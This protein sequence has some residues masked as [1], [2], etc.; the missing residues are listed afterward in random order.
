MIDTTSHSLVWFRNDLRLHDNP[1]LDRALER[2]HPI[3]FLYI[4]ETEGTDTRALGGASQWWLH[5]SLQALSESLSWKGATLTLRTGSPSD[6]FRDIRAQHSI[7]HVYWNRRYA[8]DECEADARL[9]AEL[10]SDGI[11]VE[12]FSSHLLAEPW[13]VKTRTDGHF[14]VFSPFWRAVQKLYQP[15]PA[16]SLPNAFPSAKADSEAIEDWA[17]TPTQPNWAKGFHEVWTP[18]EAS[19][20]RRLHYFLTE[21]LQ[22]YATE[23]NRPDMLKTSMLSP[24]LRFGEISP[25][26]IW[27][28]TQ[29][30]MA[31]DSSLEKD[32]MKFLAEV[33]WRDFS[34]NLLF[35]YPDIATENYNSAFDHFP[36]TRDT[37]MLK[38]WQ[39]GQTGY[40]IVDAGMRQ[41]WQTGWMHNRVRMIVASF[42]TKHLLIDWREGERW[43]WD[44][45]VDADPANNTA[46]WQW[47]AGSGADAAPYFRI[48]NPISQGQ[49]YDPDGAYVRQWV[50]ELSLM[51]ERF[52]HSPWEAPELVSQAAGVQLGTTYPKPIVD[53]ATARAR[54]LQAYKDMKEEREIA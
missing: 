21:R 29:A 24:H 16:T 6:V 13:T 14:R 30:R 45:L 37:S 35:Y 26:A 1:A 41:L 42:L 51:P 50:P 54:A 17:L 28:E 22:G 5:H 10:K 18:G 38:L 27:R 25:H 43:F 9:K 36:W 52:I 3:I 32:G 53:H 11:Q 7:E 12:S 4:R 31:Q 49:T 15:V 48:F 34:Y 2:G 46:S 33:A 8:K 39:K 47:T 44:T 19:A 23:R 40:P 20:K